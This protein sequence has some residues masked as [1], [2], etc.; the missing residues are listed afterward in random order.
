M[1]FVLPEAS[2]YLVEPQ[3]LAQHV[4]E[5][6]LR[7][8][9]TRLPEIYAEGHIPSAVHI[10]LNA[11][12]YTKD[13]IDGML[14]EPD[15][16]AATAGQLG[17]DQKT[18]IVVYDD[19]F[20][21]LASRVAWSFL[22]YG[23]ANVALL[24]GGWDAWEAAGLP[25]SD[26]AH[27]P[28]PAVFEPSLVESN[29]ASYGWIQDQLESSE[30]VLLDVRTPDEYDRGHLPNA[31]LWHWENGTALETTFRPADN[32]RAELASIGVTPDKEIVTY[33]QSGVR[34]AHTYFLLRNLGF[35]NVRMYDGSWAE[36]SQKEGN[37]SHAG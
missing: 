15:V 12:R 6:H 1:P 29:L 4:D 10:D 22:H 5:P 25:I 2:P 9:D 18:A 3:W 34:A 30:V 37:A 17:I 21:Q 20:G 23:L 8:L 36:W 14:I 16:F 19:Y 13:D 11:L 35:E 7:I 27:H 26:V 28:K 33:C 31:V 24:N 32:L